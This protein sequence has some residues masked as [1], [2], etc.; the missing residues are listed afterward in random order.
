MITP[1]QNQPIHFPGDGEL[2]LADQI[3]ARCDTKSFN[4]SQISR[5]DD[6]VNFQVAIDPT[7][8]LKWAIQ[9]EDGN[10]I[11]AD[12]TEGHVT[13]NFARTIAWVTF[14]W[15]DIL[16]QADYNGCYTICISSDDCFQAVKDFIQNG[17]FD[18]TDNWTL[19]SAW[20]ISGGVLSVNGAPPGAG[21][22]T[23]TLDTDLLS[24][25]DYNITFEVSNYVSGTLS[26]RAESQTIQNI[27][28]NGSYSID[29]TAT[30]DRSNINFTPT[31]GTNEY[32]IDNVSVTPL[33]EPLC[34]EPINVQES[35]N[36]CTLLLRWTNTEDAFGFEYTSFPG[37][38]AEYSHVLRIQ[39]NLWHPSYSKDKTVFT[40]SAQNSTI[41]YSSTSK[42]Y[43]VETFLLPEYLHDALSIGL[44]HDSFEILD[45]TKSSN[46]VS[47]VAEEQDYEPQWEED[48]IFGR[49]T[50]NVMEA[51]PQ[52]RENSN[53]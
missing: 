43:E 40:D 12:L 41:L 53:C 7:D 13:Y 17:G 18:N 15:E 38:Y 21:T 22:A 9:D 3:A 29:F 39:G 5:I 42:K 47:Y 51:T 11:Y 27:T 10:V 2:S 50:F 52:K 31:S 8:V 37:E 28:A 24:G 44:E 1:I 14:R 26:V 36:D 33:F 6:E 16:E 48:M 4:F 20:T 34:S 30:A 45:E 32:T 19:G 49:V 46:F 23:Q 35:F 25:C